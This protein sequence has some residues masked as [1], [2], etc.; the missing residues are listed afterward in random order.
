[1]PRK[2]REQSNTK[3]YH[4]ILR[5]NSKQDIFL[6]KQDYLKL[7]K[8]I[9][10][11]KKIYNYN[12]YSYCL[13]TNHVHLIIFD[14]NDN[15]SKIL[16]SITI[17]YSSY[18]NKKYERVGHVFQNRF[19]SKNIETKEYLLNVCRYIHKNPLKAGMITTN[20][21]EWSSYK[22]YI[23]KSIRVNTK[24]ILQLLGNNRQEAIENF[25][26][27]HKKE[28][29]QKQLNK[30][31]EYEM[32]EKLNDEQVERYLAEIWNLKYSIDISNFSTEKRREYLKMIKDLRGISISQI[33]RVTGISRRIIQK[34][35]KEK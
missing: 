20:D 2:A 27:F 21:Y 8:E 6:D 13:M 29:E 30:L 4:I 22:E 28:D 35:I 16:Q 10:N 14:I 17:R 5:G 3:V 25:I 7:L 15:I 24:T 9:D 19:L 18:F 34:T 33:S 1:M 26:E 11:T 31:Y 23:D 12:L 32:I